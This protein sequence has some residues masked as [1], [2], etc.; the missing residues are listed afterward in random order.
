M[1]KCTR[2]N[3]NTLQDEKIDLS[4]DIDH[5][6]SKE[7]KITKAELKPAWIPKDQICTEKKQN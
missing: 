1:K 4:C 5:I 3:A 7:I 2:G 6:A